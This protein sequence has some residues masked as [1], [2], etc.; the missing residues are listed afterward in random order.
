MNSEQEE[1]EALQKWWQENGRVVV[2][3][4]VLGLGGVFGWTTWQGYQ[5]RQAVQASRL[6]TS[7]VE[8]AA[9]DEHADAESQA[10]RIVSEHPGSGYATLASLV[11][12]KSALARGEPEAAERRL[13]WV[14][15]NAR[16]E[17]MAAL[18][19]IRLARLLRDAERYDESLAQ[20]DRV[21]GASFTA[22]VEELRGDVQ[23]AAGDREAAKQSY[24][25]ALGAPGVDAGMRARLQMKR[26][27]LGRTRFPSETR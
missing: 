11:A 23:L 27:D 10:D 4:V 2:A 26:D 17:E 16:L 24:E 14:I 22:L 15:D 7:V 18:A 1:L 20:L 8:S 25:A 12:A 6:Y 19:R 9:A 3:G 21:A 13:R 5:E